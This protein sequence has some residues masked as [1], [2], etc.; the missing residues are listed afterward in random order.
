MSCVKSPSHW[1]C[2]PPCA[3]CPALLP[4]HSGASLLRKAPRGWVSGSQ[5]WEPQGPARFG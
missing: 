5:V 4:T 2:G 3:E 1:G